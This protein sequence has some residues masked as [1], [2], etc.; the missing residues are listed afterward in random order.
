MSAIPNKTFESAL[1]ADM[2]TIIFDQ[3]HP[4]LDRNIGKSQ[5]FLTTLDGF[6]FTP[7]SVFYDNLSPLSFGTF[8]AVKLLATKQNQQ[9]IKWEF[10]CSSIEKESMFPHSKKKR[11]IKREE[12]QQ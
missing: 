11:D 3:I 9:Q 12:K 7:N 10:D 6:F 8:E 4:I 1:V 2:M 5:L